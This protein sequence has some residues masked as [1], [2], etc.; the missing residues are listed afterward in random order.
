MK[1]MFRLR[2]LARTLHLLGVSLAVMA[3]A[4]AQ[5]VTGVELPANAKGHAAIAALGAHLPRVAMA[6]GLDGQALTTLLRTQ[7]SLG[8]DRKGALVFACANQAVGAADSLAGPGTVAI[9]TSTGG[10]TAVDAFKLHSL[11]GA[12]RILYLDFNGHTTTGTLWN[13]NFAGGA[14]ITSQPFDL[15]GSPTT[16]STAEQDFIRRVWQRVAED[17]APFNVDVTTEDPGTEA[18]RNAGGG[19]SVYGMRVV[20]SPTNFYSTSAGGVAYVGSFNWNTDTPCF[21]FTGQLANGEKYIAECVS[22]EAG[23]TLGLYHDGLG[24][25]APTEY[26][27][28]QGNWAPIMGNSYYK[29]VTQ[30]SR[31]EYA[32]ANNTQD[33]L[34]VVSGYISRLGDDHGNTLSTATALPGPSVVNGG[35]LETTGDLDVF[36]FDTGAGSITLNIQCPSPAPNADLKAELL[37]GSGAVIL[38]SDPTT[39]SVSLTTTVTAGTYYLR[40]SGVGSGDPVTT[41]YSNYASLGD[42][43]ITGSLVSTGLKQA[44]IA[45]AAATTLSGTVPLTVTFG[46][47][48]SY[49]PDGTIVSYL[50]NFGSGATSNLASPSY[51]FSTAGTFTVTLTVTDNDGLSA[52][53]SVG[54]TVLPPPN[55][56]PVAVLTASA[57]NGTAPLPVNFTGGT[58][59]DPDGSIASYAWT[60][61]DGT[62]ST[63]AA[64]SKTYSSAG[65]YSVQL[66]VTDNRGGS[67]TAT[68]S[69]VVTADRSQDVDVAQFTLTGKSEPRG[70]SGIA[71]IVV[72]DRL[73]RV[74]SGVTV[75]VTWS[76]LLSGKV[77]AVTNA[78]GVVELQS[79]RTKKSGSLTA[80]ITTVN[81][82]V[83]SVYDTTISPEVTVRAISL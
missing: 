60:F 6:Y 74:V 51:T 32:N 77:T 28:G 82:A 14:T 2:T 52:T 12:G 37:N 36:R 81:P 70:K 29:A 83:G 67:S 43:V 50:W 8:V 21:A 25:S 9:A 63:L 15:D 68:T 55:Q 3:S 64:P 41:G 44:P 71:T 49:D 17:F 61:G 48:G 16:F 26:Y 45:A 24:G 65:T 38:T 76:G 20:I 27:A 75:A 79:S 10:T 54:I 31:G 73:G 30:F 1:T 7:P 78:N 62:T 66:K 69:I 34:T 11:P 53:A 39:L 35:T 5:P 13:S 80:S 40:L 57:T 47:S 4:H 33:D 42:Y 59:Y 18:L 56:L 58:S 23:H 22:H 72:K 46:S 19:D